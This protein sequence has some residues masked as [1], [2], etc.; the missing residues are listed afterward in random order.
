MK[1]LYDATNGKIYHAVPGGGWFY[2]KHTTNI[3]LT[4]MTVD[5]LAPANQAICQDLRKVVY[6]I[7]AKGLGKY[8]INTTTGA[9]ME[10]E[11]WVEKVEDIYG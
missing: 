4:E 9:I 5:E 11:G 6:K 10:R 2:F 3:P 1:I 7:D 8:Y